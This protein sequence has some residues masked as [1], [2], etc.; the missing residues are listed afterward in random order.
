MG[1]LQLRTIKARL[2]RSKLLQAQLQ[3]FIESVQRQ[4]ESR[5]VKAPLSYIRPARSCTFQNTLF[6]EYLSN[7]RLSID[8]A[9]F[10]QPSPSV[11]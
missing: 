4:L 3:R 2:A 7:R 9:V 10:L 5:Q 11:D 1:K 6:N 8:K